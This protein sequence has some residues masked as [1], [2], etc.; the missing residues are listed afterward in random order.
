MDIN[1]E[2]RSTVLEVEKRRKGVDI[3]AEEKGKDGGEVMA[4]VM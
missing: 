2:P 4:C 1:V 3:V